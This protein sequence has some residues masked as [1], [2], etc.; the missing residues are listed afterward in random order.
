GQCDSVYHLFNHKTLD[1]IPEAH[2]DFERL[3]QYLDVSFFALCTELPE[4]A[5]KETE[6]FDFLL[7]AL[8]QDIEEQGDWLEILTNKRQL[9][10][11]RH[12]MIVIGAEGAGCLGRGAEN[13]LRWYEAGL[14]FVGLTWNPDNRFAGGC[15]GGGALT[16][17]GRELVQNCNDLGILIDASHISPK[18]FWQL[19]D[20]APMPFVMSHT[21][22]AALNPH[23]GPYPR[24]ID[25]DQLRAMAELGGVVGI[26]FVPDFLGS[27]A[28]IDRICEHV[29]HAAE[30]MGI[31]HVALGSD[32]DGAPM[33]DG[34]AG[35]Q[36]LPLVYEGLAARG[37]SERDIC[38]VAG[39]NLRDLL[40]RVLP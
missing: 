7:N 16:Q 17:E 33:P 2:L 31:D 13:L 28:T 11:A 40:R 12:T 37:F 26:T 22:C 27:P 19:A 36:S 32:F 10:D 8:V 23:P 18:S 35:V 21:C 20:F 30:I 34:M 39:D 3:Q 5:G 1:T 4:H 38:R 29:E 14:R 9:I 15:A 24:N 25:D 6:T